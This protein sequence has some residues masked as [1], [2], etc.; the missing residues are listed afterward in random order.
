MNQTAD[1]IEKDVCHLS[2]KMMLLVGDSVLFS[3]FSTFNPLM[4]TLKPQSNG[5]YT[6]VQ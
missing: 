2:S 1:Q 6:A 3:A 4:G 5:H